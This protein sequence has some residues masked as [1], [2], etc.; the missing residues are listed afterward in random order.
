MITHSQK[1][2]VLVGIMG[3]GKTVTGQELA[4]IS[5][6]PFVDSDQIIEA[7]LNLSVFELFEKYGESEF[8]RREREII[9]QLLKGESLILASGGGAFLDDSV[10]NSIK[11]KAISVWLK[12]NIDIL[13]ERN[14]KNDLRPLLKNMDVES[15][16][17][18]LMDVRYP[19]YAE[20]DIAIVTDGQTPQ[21][22]A[23]LIKME[24]DRLV[25]RKG[26]AAVRP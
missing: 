3:S 14:K 25:S 24:I 13:V 17:R 20:A 10:R 18:E 1:T 19:V 16:L 23:Q 15:R 4:H 22:T 6:I 2:I 7:Q 9:L 21:E 26:N 11:E 12:P 5:E 8:R